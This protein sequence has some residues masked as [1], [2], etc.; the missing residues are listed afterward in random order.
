MIH[1]DREMN[2]QLFM[3]RFLLHFSLFLVINIPPLLSQ[4]GVYHDCLYPFQCGNIK[5]NYP[6]W[7][8]Y[9]PSF[10]GHPD[11]KLECGDLHTPTIIMKGVKYNVLSIDEKSQT[12]R[13][14]RA[15]FQA[16]ICRF[17]F[18]NTTIFSPLFSYSSGYKMIKFL[19]G[20][21]VPPAQMIAQESC[22]SGDIYVKEGADGPGECQTSVI[23][24]INGSLISPAM[25]VSVLEQGLKE[26]FDVR[27]NMNGMKCE[28]CIKSNGSCGYDIDTNQTICHCFGQQFASV[29]ACPSSQAFP[30]T[31]KF[32][33]GVRDYTSHI[34]FL[35]K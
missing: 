18:T 17:E 2:F 4:I 22:D 5:A 33:F 13:I 3:S 1:L 34:S 20:C 12:M 30:G 11:L 14:S 35:V 15:D 25:R 16:G 31:P 24:P 21:R 27:W 9:R 8:V 26:G 10:C 28:D 6:F 19:Y 29:T 32:I 23:F 7:G